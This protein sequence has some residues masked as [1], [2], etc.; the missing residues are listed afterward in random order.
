MEH[1][2]R[3]WFGHP[4]QVWCTAS[5]PGV[6]FISVTNIISRVVYSKCLYSFG[7][8]VRNDSVYIVVPLEYNYY[9]FYLLVYTMFQSGACSYMCCA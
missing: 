3:V 1:P 5:H 8:V 9:V 6:S 2:C 7:Q 4:V